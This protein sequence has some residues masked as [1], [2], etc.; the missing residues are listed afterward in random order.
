MAGTDGWFQEWLALVLNMA[1]NEI[2]ELWGCRKILTQRLSF[3]N[4][5]HP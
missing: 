5:G 3:G 1:V 4:S 2:L